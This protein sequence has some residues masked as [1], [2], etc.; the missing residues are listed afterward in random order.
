MTWDILVPI[1]LFGVLKIVMSSFPNSTVGWFIS[2]FEIHP[3]LSDADVSVSIDGKCLESEDKT[4]VIHYFNE[5]TF[6]ERYPVFP[7]YERAYLHP[8][9]GGN[10]LVIDTKGR[11]KTARLFVYIYDDH[12]N[13]VKQYKKKVVAYKLLSDSLQKMFSASNRDLA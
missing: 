13:V 4:Q 9:N 11:K 12:V 5:A 6:V 2:K 3:K 7:G 10:P 1:I 8:E